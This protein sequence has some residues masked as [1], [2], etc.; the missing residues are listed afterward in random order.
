[1]VTG[2]NGKAGFRRVSIRLGTETVAAKLGYERKRYVITFGRELRVVP[3]E[4]LVVSLT[5]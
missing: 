1:L 5:A 2:G 3:G 4:A